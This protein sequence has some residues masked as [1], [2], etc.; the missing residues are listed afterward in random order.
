M[1]R[2]VTLLSLAALT[3]PALE[4]QSLVSLA[5]PPPPSALPPP[6]TPPP[7]TP[8]K[9]TA[10]G[11]LVSFTSESALSDWAASTATG[12]K[13]RLKQEMAVASALH[14][15]AHAVRT[16]YIASGSVAVELEVTIPVSIAPSAQAARTFVQ[17]R[18]GIVRARLEADLGFQLAGDVLLS[19]LSPPPPPLPPRTKPVASDAPSDAHSRGKAAGSGPELHDQ[20]SSSAFA[21]AQ[22][23]QLA[24][25]RRTLRAVGF[26][27]GAFAVVILLAWCALERPCR[28]CRRAKRG[29]DEDSDEACSRTESAAE[30]AAL[31][32]RCS[33][34][35]AGARASRAGRCDGAGALRQSGGA[36]SEP[37]LVQA[38][39]S[40]G[41]SGESEASFTQGDA[42]PP[43]PPRRLS[44][45][46]SCRASNCA[47]PPQ[48]AAPACSLPAPSPQLSESPRARWA[49]T[50]AWCARRSSSTLGVPQ[51][52][53]SP[54][55]RE[56]V[57][58]WLGVTGAPGFGLGILRPTRSI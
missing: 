24:S 56:R 4:Q 49:A 2:A 28:Q 53:A 27:C 26:A 22:A 7:R 3:P 19:P 38:L 5:R 14:L 16:L 29:S 45:P 39:S 31:P 52:A 23:A 6:R 40:L 9:P 21:R 12:A 33:G 50:R 57:D 51:P 17:L 58:A 46:A 37:A 35:V 41:W 47:Q 15:D 55:L 11:L 8:S 34:V 1:A 44:A 32:S 13:R 10:F 25:L 18:A 30:S 36:C 20:E 42:S 48:R 54:E 43:L